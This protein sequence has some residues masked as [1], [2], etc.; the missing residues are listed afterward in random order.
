MRRSE[1]RIL[2]SAP[3]KVGGLVKECFSVYYGTYEIILP[4]SSVEF[5]YGKGI[6]KAVINFEYDNQIYSK[7]LIGVIDE[8]YNVII[9]LVPLAIMPKIEFFANDL[10]VIKYSET[11]DENNLEYNVFSCVVSDGFL[12]TKCS[13]EAHDF[14]VLDENLVMLKSYLNDNL[15]VAL[16]NPIQEDLI[17]PYY[18]YISDFKYNSVYNENVART[19]LNVTDE[20]NNPL[21]SIESF[22]NINDSS[23]DINDVVTMA[24]EDVIGYNR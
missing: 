6:V 24:I 3:F 1:V 22:I 4:K 15:I 13:L 7:D 21:V 10:C 12:R 18:S 9:N 14:E 20:Y 2:F 5:K 23:L 8:D 17:T 11:M 16:Y 19:L